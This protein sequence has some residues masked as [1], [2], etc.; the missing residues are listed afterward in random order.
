MLI[1]S[2]NLLGDGSEPMS[3]RGFGRIHL[4]AGMPYNGEGSMALFVQNQAEVGTDTY[5]SV[6]LSVDADAGLDLRATLSWIDPA[7]SS[8]SAVQLVNDLDLRGEGLFCLL[9]WFAFK[10]GWHVDLQGLVWTPE[11]LFDSAG[12]D[13]G[14]GDAA[15]TITPG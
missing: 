12:G 13:G 15:A 1:N 11:V 5:N 6:W 10:D 7:A 14:D 8:I 9:E 4:E 3:Y 2:A